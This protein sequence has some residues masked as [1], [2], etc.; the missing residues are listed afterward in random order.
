MKM[1]I[2]SLIAFVLLPAA[3][4]PML[5]G[6][7]NRQPGGNPQNER[8]VSV[9]AIVSTSSDNGGMRTRADTLLPSVTIPIADRPEPTQR[10]TGPVGYT[11]AYAGG[12]PNRHQ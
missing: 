5:F 11:F 4:L 12:E 8:E 2:S 7:P 10:N 6:S 9:P 3:S 1:K